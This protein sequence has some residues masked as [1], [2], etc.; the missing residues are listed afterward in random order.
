M[1]EHSKNQNAAG[2]VDL[3]L[4]FAAGREAAPVPD[5]A[6]MTAVLADA[7]RVQADINAARAPQ[8]ISHAGG[9]AQRGLWAQFRAAIGGW[10]ALAGLASVATAGLWLGAVQPVGLGQAAS[11][12]LAD[13]GLYFAA[14]DGYLVD[15]MPSFEFDLGES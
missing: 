14:Q 1:T 10:P 13:A 11:L 5:A 6:L 9:E 4:F 3:D 7:Q 2:D 12:Y 8:A 15:V